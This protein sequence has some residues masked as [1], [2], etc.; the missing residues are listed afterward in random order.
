MAGRFR[1]YKMKSMNVQRIA[2]VAAGAALVGAAFAG[3]VQVDQSGLSGV[4]FFSGGEPQ[5]KVAIG[6]K[7][8]ASDVVAGANIAAMIGNLAYVDK[9]I[10]VQGA[11]ALSCSG[12][13]AGCSVDAA[14][15]KVAVSV[16]TPG[17]SSANAYLMKTYILDNIDDSTSETTK[18]STTSFDG[19]ISSV[20]GQSRLVTKDHTAV[21]SLPNDGKVSN[22]KNLN[23]KQEQKAYLFAKT[24]YDSSTDYKQI[25]AQDPRAVYTITFSDPLPI[26]YDTAKNRSGSD[27]C[28]TGDKLEEAHTK[29]KF[30]GADWVITGYTMTAANTTVIKTVSIGKEQGYNP[31]MNID[32]TITAPNGAKVTLKSV[33]PFGYGA[34]TQPYASF[35]VTSGSGTVTTETL[36]AGDEKEVAGV[37]VKVNKVFPG[38]NN[39]NYADVSV[40]SDKI[41][42]DNNVQIDSGTHKYW[43]ASIGTTT[44]GSSPAIQNLSLYSTGDPAKQKYKAGESYTVIRGQEAFKFTFE[45]LDTPSTDT[46]SFAVANNTLYTN[47]S[48][49]VTGEF[50]QI[51]S[52]V[53]NAFQFGSTSTSTVYIALQNGTTS[54]SS[55]VAAPT[56]QVSHATALYQNPT[57]GYY[58]PVVGANLT[59]YYSASESSNLGVSA[60]ANN[61]GAYVWVKEFN[62]DSQGGTASYVTVLF[63][64]A[65]DQFVNTIGSTT[66]DKFGYTLSTG[67]PGPAD[68]PSR[69][70]GYITERG[71]KLVDVSSKGAQ[72][73]YPKTVQRGKYTLT[74]AGT[75]ASAGKVTLNLGVGESGEVDTGY[76]ATV[77]S[78]D[79]TA[80]GGS[81]GAGS[82]SGVE[83]LSATGASVTSLNTASNP[84]VVLDSAASAT[85][86][87]IV[88]GGQIVNTQYPASEALSA[89]SE[90]VVK[91]VGNKVLVAGYTAADTTAAANSL[92]QW[93][94]SNRESIRG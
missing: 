23:I 70:E 18:N 40:F 50:V 46:L 69:D 85:E 74:A 73:I 20:Q 56:A 47:S 36:Q 3:A 88:V 94:A 65:L 16:T 90:P 38:V 51:T 59:Y 11:S 2:T 80:A 49:Y 28:A 44:S 15:K 71:T 17:V 58:V 37:T 29:I 66:V 4:T 84:L 78:I 14:S 63:D 75:T 22:P 5:V 26:C 64:R 35:E 76:T 79:A 31:Y 57:D 25:I 68:N 54:N 10:A 81:T 83:G 30:L 52:T 61:S 77:D 60:F 19:Q 34:T 42:L 86:P 12:S 7:G 45:G 62:Q 55:V 33:S 21:L 9:S 53:S 41:T 24:L 39:V 6:S 43:Y 32:D 92:I 8:Q 13:A 87:L 48:T 72:L 89:G 91:V 1:W 67:T 82:V 93:L 27:V